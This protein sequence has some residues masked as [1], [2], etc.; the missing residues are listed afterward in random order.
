MEITNGLPSSSIRILMSI[1]LLAILWKC[2]KEE[3]RM[4]NVLSLLF[5]GAV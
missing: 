3:E 1:V 5:S 4:I 2:G